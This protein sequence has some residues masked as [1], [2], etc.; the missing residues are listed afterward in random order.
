MDTAAFIFESMRVV[1]S[2]LLLL[3][4]PGFALSLVIFPRLTD[5]STIDRLVYSMVPEY[6]FL[7]CICCIHRYCPWTRCDTGYLYPRHQC[8]FIAPCPVL[9]S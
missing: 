1:F 4:I 2:F 9:V 7:Y 8:F 6:Q 5:L 3:F